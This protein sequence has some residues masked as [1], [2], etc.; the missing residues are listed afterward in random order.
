MLQDVK[1]EFPILVYQDGDEWVAQSLLTSTT[2]VNKDHTK[3]LAEVSHLM[4]VEIDEA[5][6][7]A[8]G[9]LQK[10]LQ[11]IVCSAP[12]ELW[13]QFFLHARPLVSP[14]PRVNAPHVSFS[15]REVAAIAR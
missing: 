3:A 10:A 2:A 15:P 4:D 14:S 6:A 9:D 1:L 13:N 5:F 12:A 11:M 8:K 7:D